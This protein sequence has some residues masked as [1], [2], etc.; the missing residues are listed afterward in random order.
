MSKG[1]T[2][3]AA[4]IVLAVT[5]SMGEATPFSPALG[6]SWDGNP[7]G[8]IE[9]ILGDGWVLGHGS[10]SPGTYRIE[11]GGGYSA[12]RDIN[13][14]TAT[15]GQIVLPSGGAL[16][17]VEL[18][19]SDPWMLV[20]HTP[21]VANA[22]SDGAQWLWRGLEF[23]LEDINVSGGDRDYQDLWGRVVPRLV[24]PPEITPE[25]PEI[26]QQPQPVPE[27]ATL[28]LLGTG[29]LAVARRIRR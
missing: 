17:S 1:K 12:W 7:P 5:A 4:A 15:D 3:A 23:G 6:P 16:D 20:A 25:I 11:F 26:P 18:V 9:D 10:F 19:F 2:A 13:T 14:V 21:S 22:Y 24:P 27:P 8:T 28:L 29:L